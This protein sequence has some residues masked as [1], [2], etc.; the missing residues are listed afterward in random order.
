MSEPEIERLR[1][2]IVAEG[3]VRRI[4]E[5]VPLAG[6]RYAYLIETPFETLPKFV[7][8]TTDA[9]NANV[10]IELRCGAEWSAREHFERH[11]GQPS[12]GPAPSFFAQ[13][14]RVPNE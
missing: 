10:D 13:K 11:Y 6:G 2:L 14:R 3:D 4:M 9:Q 7:V 5:L 1:A 12:P 8:G